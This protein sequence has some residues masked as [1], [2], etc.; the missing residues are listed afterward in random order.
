M[1]KIIRTAMERSRA[2]LTLLVMLWVGGILAFNSLP[3][4][5][6]PDITIPVIYVSV[7]HEGIS[8]E[9]AERLLVRPLEQELRS[10]DGLKE[11]RS[12]GAEGYGSITLEFRAGF[13]PE[14]A[15]ADVRDKV[16]TAKTKLPAESDEPKVLE[17]NFSQFPVINIGLS[18]PMSEVVLVRIARDLKREIEG[19]ADVLEVEIG[20]DRED[21]LELVADQQVLERYGIDYAQL[22]SLVSSNNRLVA[23]GNL[24]TG[25]GRMAIKVPGVIEELDDLLTM[26]IKSVDGQV[27]T[28]GDV[29]TVQRTFKDPTGFARIDGNPAVVLEVSKRAG[30]NVI[31]TIEQVKAVVEQRQMFWPPDLEVTYITD[32]SE[33][34]QDILWDLLNNVL[35]AV[36]LVVIVIVGVMGPRP[37]L[38]VGLT[39][40]GAF[41][42]G[43]LVIQTIGFTLNIVV[44]FSLILVAGLLVDGAIVVAELAD[45]YLREGHSRREAFA[46]AAA[47][48]SW[49]V[50][51]STLTTIA[52][53]IPLLVWPGIVGEFMKFLPATVIICLLASL[54]MAL[55]FM[56]VM[57]MYI[58]RKTIKPEELDHEQQPGRFVAWYGAILAHLLK[59]PAKTLVMALA[60]MILTY[61]AYARFNNGLEFFPE[62]EPESAQVLVHASGDRSV[63]EK[64][65]LVR[66]V[67]SRLLGMPEVQDIYARSFAQAT[68]DMTEDVIGVLQ[69]QFVDWH[70][71]RSA[72]TI[73]EE[74]R[75]RTA[76]LPLKLEFRKQEGGPAAGKPI[77]L[78]V[79]GDNARLED[80]V[81]ELRARLQNLGGLVDISDNRPLPGIEWRIEVDREK[82]ARYGLNVTMVGNVVQLVT[83]GLLIADYRPD[84]AE[85][86]VDIRLRLP[87]EERS[88]ETLGRLMVSTPQGAVPISNFTTLT[89]A[90][91]TGTLHRVDGARTLTV[92]ADVAPGIQVDERLRALKAN[93][94]ENPIAG[95]RIQFAGQDEDQLEA[96]QFLS[97]AFV[98]AVSL[99][100]LMLIIQF[101]SIYQAMLVLSAIVFSTAG[102]LIGLMVTGRPFG[103]VMVGL[104]TIALAGIVVNNNII[105]IDTY[106]ELKARG[107]A[108]YEAALETG[109]LRL[110]PVLLT[111]IT[112]VL[113][114]IPMVLGMNVDL[115]TPS[116]GVN[117]PSTQWWTE[118]SS[119]IAGGLTFATFLTLL[120]TPCMLVLGERAFEKVRKWTRKEKPKASPAP[121]RAEDEV[122]HDQLV[123]GLANDM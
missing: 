77:K 17:I 6:N 42:S 81:T 78:K 14:I 19:I 10:L 46:R 86:E 99:M 73:L 52:V 110:R 96:M 32:E 56:P 84:D 60:L 49:P 31:A 54:F 27:V 48:M 108:A 35:F 43:L 53:F 5:S 7:S 26:P 72:D 63:W 105:L 118:L 29:A 13:N 122:A 106:N 39:I 16:D 104:G 22:F 95:A 23:A 113:G 25:A 21:L 61:V 101:N 79:S 12:I 75:Q 15:L 117:A 1:D 111:A 41:L 2:S 68:G 94:M 89:P 87:L 9:D 24:D 71:R 88:L 67:E 85:E 82:A 44:L 51:A 116:I 11:M 76:D 62:V 64:D 114:L 34:I 112:T 74:M 70:E 123:S 66:L 55:V 121:E 59:A 50:I 109:K 33:Q 65:S 58:G 119:A 97:G 28:F 83:T 3:K 38:L 4:E 107:Y 98:V 100:A 36:I 18:G 103:V 80:S 8:P 92:E 102:I 45:R 37:A 20:G 90:P 30:A 57:G 93:L 69:F 40:P 115:L 91:K 120:V 47:R